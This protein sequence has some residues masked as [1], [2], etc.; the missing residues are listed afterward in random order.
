MRDEENRQDGCAEVGS[1]YVPMTPLEHTVFQK[2]GQ[3]SM[4]WETLHGAGVFDSAQA[5]R[6]AYDILNA[7]NEHTLYSVR[8]ETALQRDVIEGF[9]RQVQLLRERVEGYQAAMREN[10]SRRQEPLLGLA[11]NQQLIQELRARIEVHFPGGLAYRTHD[12]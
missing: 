9:K 8:R 3:A 6:V 11:T 10:E 12:S 7:V 1:D 4:C 2:V 5:A